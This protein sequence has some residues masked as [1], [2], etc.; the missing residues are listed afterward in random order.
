MGP[1]IEIISASILTLKGLMDVSSNFLDTL[2]THGDRRWCGTIFLSFLS[3][4]S[5]CLFPSQLLSAL[6]RLPP[7]YGLGAL[8]GPR[9]HLPPTISFCL[10]GR[11]GAQGYLAHL[12]RAACEMPVGGSGSR[13]V[14]E[15][16]G[17]GVWQRARLA[18]LLERRPSRLSSTIHSSARY[19]LCPYCVL[20]TSYSVLGLNRKQ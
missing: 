12:F 17:R 1:W 15:S 7:A 20:G 5:V 16:G 4:A 10:T 6:F 13:G 3:S 14:R 9:P 18:K 11:R 19:S 2:I 8:G